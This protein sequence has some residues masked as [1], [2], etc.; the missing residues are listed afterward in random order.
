MSGSAGAEL[1]TVTLRSNNRDA[2][3][4]VVELP[5]WQVVVE[6][7][8]FVPRT[9]ANTD[10]DDA[11]GEVAGPNDGRDVHVEVGN[12]TCGWREGVVL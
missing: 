5:L 8:H 12:L 10:H 3:H 6:V 2:L 11:Q 7:L 1:N 9:V 4:T